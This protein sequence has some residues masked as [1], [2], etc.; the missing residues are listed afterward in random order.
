MR[1]LPRLCLAAA[2]ALTL[3]AHAARPLATEDA[4]VLDRGRCEWES[5]AGQESER[6]APVGHSQT[7]QVGCGI[8]G[9][10]QL[11]LPYTHTRSGGVAASGAAVGGKFALV[12][13][14]GNSLGLAL[15]WALT[16]QQSPGQAM[17]HESSALNLAATQA[18]TA[19]WTAHANLG[20]TRSHSAGTSAGTWSLAGEWAVQEGFDVMAEIYGEQQSKPWQAAGVRY[21]FSD[22]LS[23][24]GSFAVQ[25]DAPRTRLWTVGVNVAF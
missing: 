2:A 5:F 24:N 11:A 19:A 23:V 20:W 10:M 25:G 13:R 22:N 4:D 3:P 14:E 15:A 6:D 8:G 12:P 21:A 7:M 9:R 17:Q 18:I 1:C 16:A